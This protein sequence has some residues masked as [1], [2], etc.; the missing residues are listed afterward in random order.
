MRPEKQQH[1]HLSDDVAFGESAELIYNIESW[2]PKDASRLEETV[3][4]ELG[5]S[6]GG[7]HDEVPHTKSSSDTL[8]MLPEG[9]LQEEARHVFDNKDSTISGSEMKGESIELL[10]LFDSPSK[11]WSFE[12]DE[13]LND[14]ED[15]YYFLQC[16][17]L[18]CDDHSIH[19]NDNRCLEYLDDGDIC[20]KPTAFLNSLHFDEVGSLLL[21]KAGNQDPGW[22]EIGRGRSAGIKLS[23]RGIL[24]DE[25]IPC[26]CEQFN[27]GND[28]VSM[29]KTLHSCTDCNE[30]SLSRL[31][32]LSRSS[33]QRSDSAKPEDCNSMSTTII[34]ICKQQQDTAVDISSGVGAPDA[35][36]TTEATTKVGNYFSDVLAN[37]FLE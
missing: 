9:Q 30:N 11:C 5:F 31:L 15:N 12:D 3:T 34:T 22:I 25:F 35:K 2:L 26:C 33:A 36:K 6:N 27:N 28:Y 4:E 8:I 17:P 23:T 14:L 19:C 1:P 24:P 16:I 13:F 32:L 21:V 7:A 20:I 18:N 37:S 10:A 29:T